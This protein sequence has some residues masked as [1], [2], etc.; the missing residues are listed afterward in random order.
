MSQ[1]RAFGVEVR[2]GVFFCTAMASDGTV[3]AMRVFPPGPGGVTQ[4]LRFVERHHSGNRKPMIGIVDRTSVEGA[5]DR[6]AEA[7]QREGFLVCPVIG[8]VLAG[9]VRGVPLDGGRTSRRAA[10]AMLRRGVSGG[11]GGK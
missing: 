2:D 7:M 1:G 10:R 11:S 4:F 8:E 9:A 6:L 3:R 5:A